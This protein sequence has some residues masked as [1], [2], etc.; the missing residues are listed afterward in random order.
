MSIHA[1]ARRA[2]VAGRTL[3]LLNAQVD[4]LRAELSAL[5]SNVA[6]VQRDFGDVRAVHLVEANE[7]LVLAALNAETIA[8]NAVTDLAALALSTQYD[9]LTETPNRMLMLDR[10][11]GAIALAQRRG[12]RVAVLFVDLDHFKQIN[13]TLGHAIGDQVLQL[14]ALRLQSSVR[15]SDT[16]SRHGGDEFVVLLAEI[17]RPED[18]ALIAGNMLAALRAPSRV[19]DHLLHVSASIGIA[20]YPEDGA[21]PATLIGHA[22]EAMYRVKREHSGGI[23]FH[24]DRTTGVLPTSAG[25]HTAESPA[26]EPGLRDLRDVNEQLVLTALA[27]RERLDGDA[28]RQ[29]RQS[30][31]LA[32]LASELR[33][34]LAPLRAAAALLQNPIHGEALMSQLQEIIEC[35]VDAMCRRIDTLIAG[36]AG[37]DRLPRPATQAVALRELLSLAIESS[38]ATMDARRQHLQADLPARSLR[39]EGDAAHLWQVFSKVLDNASEHALEGGRIE[40][41][42]VALAD[43]AT[44][45]VRHSGAGR[46]IVITLATRQDASSS[47]PRSETHGRDTLREHS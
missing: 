30:A 3:A 32:L 33:S 20:T 43:T 34:P 14:A 29:R 44:V 35:Q 38:R 36:S 8:E 19:G 22:D 18:A 42:V 41:A 39:V 31:Q 1:D 21:D 23:G 10:M 40:I 27:T 2:A 6:A 46:E 15:D 9:E 28:A 17:A 5:R 12:T 47:A 16:V 7:R 25:A 4:S 11:G 45:T 24:G 26:L 13:D 37:D